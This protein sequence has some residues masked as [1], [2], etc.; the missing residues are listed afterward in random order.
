MG[1]TKLTAKQ[2]LFCNEFLKDCNATK[3][4]IRAGY[5]EKTAGAIGCENLTK[6]EIHA[7]VEELMAKRTERTQISAD[8]VLNGLMI[9]AKRCMTAEPVMIWNP[10]DKVMQQAKDDNGKDVWTFDSTGA[11]RAL[12]LLGKHTGIFE[13]DNAQQGKVSIVIKKTQPLQSDAG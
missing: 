4:A 5:S 9:V 3:A 6:P 2:E 1:K 12:E 13:K 10:E 8:F 7:R 11:N